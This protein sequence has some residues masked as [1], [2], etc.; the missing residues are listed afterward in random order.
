MTAAKYIKLVSGELQEASTVETSAGAGDA[1]K[2]PNLNSSG[3]IDSSMIPSSGSL[4]ALSS[5]FLL[6][7]AFSPG[8]TGALVDV[9]GASL[10][11]PAAGSY[12]ME[13]YLSRSSPSS[14]AFTWAINVT[15]GT[16]SNLMFTGMVPLGQNSYQGNTVTVNN[17]AGFSGTITT[18]AQIPHVFWGAF[19]CT[20]SGSAQLRVNS[21]ST[22]LQVLAGSWGR[23]VRIA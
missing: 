16:I 6:S 9:T 19:T 21:G 8:S 17:T 10:T 20:A 4:P 3:Q 12:T 7:S 13:F 18:T 23:L 15:G 5:M 11:V 14:T 1:G 2:I 22:S